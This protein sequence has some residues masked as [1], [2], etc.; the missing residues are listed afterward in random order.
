MKNVIL[1]LFIIVS[2]SCL[3]QK[4]QNVYFLKNDGKE[5]SI[6]DSADFIR[7]IS[8]P[9]SAS[10]LYNLTEYYLNGNKKAIATVSSYDPFV[11]YEGTLI[12]YYANGNKEFI[13][14]YKEN[15]ILGNWTKYYEN[16][17]LQESRT[18]LSS[19]LNKG[20]SNDY[21]VNQIADSL[22]NKFLDSLGN[23]K[24]N[25]GY[26]KGD[27]LT[28]ECIDGFK[29]G[30]W[31]AYDAKKQINY[32]E[33]FKDG[34]LISGEYKNAFGRKGTYTVEEQSPMF[35]GGGKNFYDHISRSL[36]YPPEAR[37]KNEQGKVVLKCTIAVD[38]NM[39]NIKIVKSV[40]PSLDKEAIRVLLSCPKWEPGLI[41]GQPE[42]MYLIIPL[43][44]KLA[45]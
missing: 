43:V 37:Y 10:N 8:E 40:S 30:T 2:N 41:K 16:G 45:K 32:I 3:A 14:D 11:K 23:G 36:R 19:K 24:V 13:K 29:D 5:V 4:K 9:D 12:T 6:R 26:E 39:E 1:I 34:I 28:G 17:R 38:G 44:F 20:I 7:I 22:G 33:E 18:Y 42:S 15:K 21:K 25:I 35:A 27:K 31:T